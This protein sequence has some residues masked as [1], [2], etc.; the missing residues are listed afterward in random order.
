[1][2]WKQIG[3]GAVL[4]DFSAFTAWVIYEYGYVDIFRIAVSNALMLQVSIDLTIALTLVGLWMIRD[5]RERGVS[6][7]PY[8]L[9][10]LTL[11]SIGPLLYLFRRAG[12]AR[13]VPARAVGLAQA[14]R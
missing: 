11:G 1:M 5:A 6:V 2:N 4:A 9:V 12:D 7:T 14:S 10:T 13:T 8:L 3:I